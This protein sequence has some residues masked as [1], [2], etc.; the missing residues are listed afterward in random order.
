[1]P[2]FSHRGLPVADR[3]ALVDALVSELSNQ[4]TPPPQPQ[5]YENEIPQ[6]QSFHA[7]VIWDRWDGVPPAARGPIIYDA[8]ERV[9]PTRMLQLKFAAGFTFEEANSGGYLP[10]K[11]ETTIRASD[12]I[13]RDEILDE[14]IVLGARKTPFGIE[15]RFPYR[16]LADQAL[17]QLQAKF[18]TGYFSLAQ[19]VGSVGKWARS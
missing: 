1:M 14:M 5:I 19:E 17:S 6:T 13:N 10:Y 16:S 4:P 9:D 12:P 18:G 2:V 7:L 15:L 8:Y 3:G 11:I